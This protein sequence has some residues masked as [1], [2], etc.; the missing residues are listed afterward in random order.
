MTARF[1][2]AT[3]QN[4]DSTAT[5]QAC[6][7]TQA[8]A[9]VTYT[10]DGFYQPVENRTR[11][12]MKGGPVVPLKFNIFADGVKDV[13][14]DAS[15][16]DVFIQK[17]TCSSAPTGDVNILTDGETISSG[18]TELRWNGDQWV[19]NWKTPKV[20]GDTCYRIYLEIEGGASTSADFNLK[21]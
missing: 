20:S 18:K 3:S 9:G 16:I 10:I 2:D 6:A 19:F 17:I 7:T 13:S 4:F 5:S 21:K 11:N 12:V 15:L 1:T 8:V 14:G